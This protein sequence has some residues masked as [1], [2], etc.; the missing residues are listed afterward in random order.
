MFNEM[1]A[2]RIEDATK[3]NNSWGVNT[4]YLNNWF[5]YDPK[6]K[7]KAKFI[8]IEIK[9]NKIRPAITPTD[10]DKAFDVLRQHFAA[11]D[12]KSVMFQSNRDKETELQHQ[13]AA[14]MMKEQL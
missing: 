10:V 14:Q 7:G 1:K 13:E 2:I 12:R 8:S 3:V 11:L 5:Q 6:R 4:N 9:D